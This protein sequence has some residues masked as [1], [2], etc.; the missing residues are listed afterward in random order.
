MGQHSFAEQG[1]ARGNIGFGKRFSLG[2][3]LDVALVGFSEREQNRAFDDGQQVVHFH[4][5]LVGN[6]VEILFSASIVQQFQESRDAARTR[7]RQSLELL[8]RGWSGSGGSG[9]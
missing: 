2:S 3:D 7:V 4:L 5:Q 1:L 8:L 9:G 6:V